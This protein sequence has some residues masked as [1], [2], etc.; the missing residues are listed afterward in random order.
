VR[1]SE[2][3]F[4]RVERQ[5]TER[6]RDAQGHVHVTVSPFPVEMQALV[7]EVWTGLAATLNSNQMERARSLSV[8]RLFPHSG[9]NTVKVEIWQDPN[10]D[11]HFAEEEQLGAGE[12]HPRAPMEMPSRYRSLLDDKPPKP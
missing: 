8:E 12:G 10:G 2:A 5:H 11:Y 6:T 9:T 7:H 4:T 1:R 3:E